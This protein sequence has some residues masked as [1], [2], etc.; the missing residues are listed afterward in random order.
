MDIN[1]HPNCSPTARDIKP[2]ALEHIA[3]G[4]WQLYVGQGREEDN[5]HILPPASTDRSYGIHASN[6]QVEMVVLSP[7][8]CPSV[9]HKV[10]RY[11][12]QG[13]HCDIVSV[14]R[15]KDYQW[16]VQKIVWASRRTEYG[17]EKISAKAKDCSCNRCPMKK[18][19]NI[20]SRR[21][22]GELWFVE[23]QSLSF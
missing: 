16:V 22:V 8:N 12:G 17:T 9:P 19:A 11:W 23:K 5:M 18:R 6:N 21:R 20:G 13:S 3:K 1:I 10:G 2:K 4:V 7:G 15:Q 14:L